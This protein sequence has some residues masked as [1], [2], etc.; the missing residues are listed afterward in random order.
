[1]SRCA[2][3]NHAVPLSAREAR[4]WMRETGFRMLGTRYLFVFPRALAI[5]RWMEPLLSPLPL[6]TQYVVWGVKG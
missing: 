1:M 4:R 3:D 6:G 5:F 2:F